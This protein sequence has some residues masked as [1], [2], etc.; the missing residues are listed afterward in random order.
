MDFRF[1]NVDLRILGPIPIRKS[2]IEDR[3]SLK[4]V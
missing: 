3:K 4:G 1:A 2:Q